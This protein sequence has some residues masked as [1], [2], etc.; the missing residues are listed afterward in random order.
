MKDPNLKLFICG[1]AGI[2]KTTLA[3]TLAMQNN[4]NYINGSSSVLWDK[5]KVKCHV[6]LV[7]K[8]ERDPDLGLRFQMDLLEYR[9][10]KIS[11]LDNYV[12]DRSPIDNWVYFL[13]QNTHNHD[14]SITRTYKDICQSSLVSHINKGGKILFLGLPNAYKPIISDGKRID[15]WFYQHLVNAIFERVLTNQMPKQKPFESDPFNFKDLDKITN[16]TNMHSFY[17][18]DY[19]EREKSILQ[20]LEL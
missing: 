1:P 6:E 20:W 16:Y 10:Q 12:T 2:G 8:I 14:E 15:N 9:N 4:I 13:L 19:V 11:G 17:S 7:N 5:Y 18:L 3:K